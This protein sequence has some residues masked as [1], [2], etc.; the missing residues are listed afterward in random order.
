M[1]ATVAKNEI[2]ITFAPCLNLNTK[3]R[4]RIK[5]VAKKGTKAGKARKLSMNL[6]SNNKEKERWKPHVK[7]S[8]PNVSFQLHCIKSEM[9]M[10]LRI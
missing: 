3:C 5:I 4:L 1:S 9:Q 7:Q 6:P 8:K 2:R 10:K